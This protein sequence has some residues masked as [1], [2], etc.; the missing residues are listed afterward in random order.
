[1]AGVDASMAALHFG[2]GSTAHQQQGA[3]EEEEEEY[4]QGESRAV[5]HARAGLCA[6]PQRAE[7][8][9]L[10]AAGPCSCCQPP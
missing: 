8:A 6:T 5:T 3:E 4:E 7:G 10:F 2:E 9:V 1:M